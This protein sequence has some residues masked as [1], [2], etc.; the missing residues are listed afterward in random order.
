MQPPQISR[1][2]GEQD[3][4]VES[5]LDRVRMALDSA[6]SEFQ[7]VRIL[8]DATLSESATIRVAVVRVMA[9]LMWSILSRYPDHAA[10][11]EDLPLWKASLVACRSGFIQA[12]PEQT[13]AGREALFTIRV[14]RSGS[15]V[16]EHPTQGFPAQLATLIWNVRED[17][18]AT[19]ECQY[20][21][22]LLSMRS[23]LV[24]VGFLKD[25]FGREDPEARSV[26]ARQAE[27]S[28]QGL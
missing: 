10:V 15:V 17:L 5:Y 27:F 1:I 14:V 13:T 2:I 6:G 7:R 9:R 24:R 25:E 18:N 11:K 22:T 4:V 21:P 8:E 19:L 26:A 3:R 12:T 28:H 16:S 23:A 20:E